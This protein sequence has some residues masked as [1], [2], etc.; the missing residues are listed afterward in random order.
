MG[1]AT[2]QGAN[3]EVPLNLV[4]RKESPFITY[5]FFYTQKH[6]WSPL[7][8]NIPTKPDFTW[9]LGDHEKGIYMY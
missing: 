9:G 1:N 5:L 7:R 4:R 3:A 8:T 2:G 6:P